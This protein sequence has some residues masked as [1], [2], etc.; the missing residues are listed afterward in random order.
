MARDLPWMVTASLIWMFF[1]FFAGLL[2]S[3]L[4][5]IDTSSGVLGC[6]PGGLTQMVLLAEDIQEANPGLVALIQTA[7]LMVVLYTVPFLAAVFAGPPSDGALS[8]QLI[9]LQAA[10]EG[11]P[12]YIGAALLPLVPAASWL[13]SR[14]RI[15]AGEFLGP[16]LLAGGLSAAGCVWPSLPAPAVNAAQL[17]IG[18][19]IGSRIQPRLMFS[20]KKLAPYALGTA[21]LLVSLTAGAS[22]FLSRVTDDSIVTW[23]LGLAP[24]GLGEVA[25]TAL[26]LNADVA[27]VTAYQLFRLFAILLIAPHFLR[28]MLLNNGMG[29]QWSKNVGN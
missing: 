1:C 18:I 10:E 22:W 17:L 2:F 7:R 5:G 6:M 20:N 12:S 27:Q 8:R 16:V 21:I 24:G 26:A 29:K 25:A 14:L 19:Y 28:W 3:K 9:A 11:W 13:A 4:V 15:P 23:F